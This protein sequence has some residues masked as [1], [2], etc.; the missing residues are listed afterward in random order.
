MRERKRLITG[1][2]SLSLVVWLCQSLR[3]QSS[4]LSAWVSIPEIIYI[5]IYIYLLSRCLYS[6]W[7]TNEE[8][9]KAICLYK[10]IMLKLHR[11]KPVISIGIQCVWEFCGKY[12]PTWILHKAQVGH[13]DSDWLES[14]FC[15]NWASY[16]ATLII[17]N[18]YFLSGKCC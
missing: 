2:I 5:H 10:M 3:L 1:G 7:F 4:L 12:L 15:V 13:A 14:D 9:W 11:Q 17:D 16:I 8:C 6:K 18:G